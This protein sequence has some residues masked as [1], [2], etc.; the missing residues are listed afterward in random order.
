MEVC[1]HIVHKDYL[2]RINNGWLYLSLADYDDDIKDQSYTGKSS[3]R[4]KYDLRNMYHNTY[5]HQW[6]I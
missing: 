4:I 6:D 5:Y 3:L 1:E 2:V